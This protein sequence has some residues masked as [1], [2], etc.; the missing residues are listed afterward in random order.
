VTAT[1]I[2]ARFEATGTDVAVS[3][4]RIVMHHRIGLLLG[5]DGHLD[6]DRLSRAVRLSLDAEPILGCAW[7]TDAFKAYWLRITDLDATQPFSS[8]ETEELDADVARFYAEEIADAGPQ[9][10]VRLFRSRDND[11]LGIKVSHVLADGQAAKQYAYLVADIYSRLGSDASYVPEPDLQ[12]RPTAKDVWARL[13]AEQ[14]RGAKKAKSWAMPSWSVPAKGSSGRGLASRSLELGP[15][16]F[17]ALKAY[18]AARNATVNDMLLAAFFRGCVARFNPPTGKPLS[19]MCTADLRRYLPDAERLP[20]ANISISG[21]LDIERVEGEPFEATLARVR[22]R[23]AVWASQCYGAGPALNAEKLTALGYG[24]TKLL[25]T[26]AM[27][28]SGNSGDTYPWF[29]NIGVIDEAR[30]LFDGQAPVSGS[31]FG[32]A[33]H[34]AAIVPTISTYRDTL[35]ICMGFCAEDIE[36]EVIE[37]V[38]RAADDELRAV[39]L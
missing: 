23:M 9:A 39:G 14:R 38:L 27:R 26:G 24:M 34:G 2:P 33:N 18:G 11:A 7:R 21:S 32:P 29:T 15:D 22:E 19:L 37:A 3:I 20:I 6:A 35:T 8:V 31:M 25:L 1:R 4:T 12:V 10:A 16:R 13:D 17:S 36:P 30:L 28:A 5:F